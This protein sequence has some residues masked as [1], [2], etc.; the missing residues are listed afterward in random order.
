[1]SSPTPSS[2]EFFGG[3]EPEAVETMRSTGRRRRFP[4]GSMI[5][6][7][8]EPGG[9]VLVLLEGRVKAFATTVEGREL[10]LSL[11]GPGDL[12]GE[13]AALGPEDSIRTASVQA[14]DTVVAQ[15]LTVAEFERFLEAHP[16]A[17]LV[18]LRSV[19]AR[20]EQAVHMRVEYG[21]H[22]VV[23]RVA[24]RL[25]ELADTHGEVVE[26]GVQVAVGLSQDEL[27]SWAVA[28]RESVAKVLGRLRRQGTIRTDRKSIV[29]L[30]VEHLRQV[31]GMQ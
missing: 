13:I 10:I 2:G 31:G 20:L 7:E 4:A 30:D 1:M 14:L 3:L 26:D 29:V 9:S 19:L 6:L 23:G 12:I 25:C 8:G 24:R 27:A 18:L 15:V 16:K 5:F 11:R 28:S 17:A 21:A 22:D